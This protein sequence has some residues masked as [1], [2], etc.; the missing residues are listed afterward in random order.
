MIIEHVFTKS[1]SSV[2]VALAPSDRWA[3]AQKLN[4]GS[5]LPVWFIW[6]VGVALTIVAVLILIAAFKHKFQRSGSAGNS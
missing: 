4:S 6:S 5:G 2:Y 3:A 1:L